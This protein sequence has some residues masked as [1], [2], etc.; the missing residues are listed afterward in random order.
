MDET[1]RTII[2]LINNSTDPVKALEEAFK[3]ALEF[4]GQHEVPL[5]TSPSSQQASA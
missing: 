5:C 3:L 1:E 2:D 4:L